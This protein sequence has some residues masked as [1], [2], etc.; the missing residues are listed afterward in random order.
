MV[1]APDQAQ[2]VTAEKGAGKQ[3]A[4]PNISIPENPH[5]DCLLVVRKSRT[6]S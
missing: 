1:A 4:I 3:N 6:K 5:G 2:L